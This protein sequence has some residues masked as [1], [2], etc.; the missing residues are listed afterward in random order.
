MKVSKLAEDFVRM[1]TFIIQARLTRPTMVSVSCLTTV[2]KELEASAT[3]NKTIFIVEYV[4]K[5]LLTVITLSTR[6][7]HK[8]NDLQRL[9]LQNLCDT[10]K[11][12][13]CSH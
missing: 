2:V 13:V 9:P 11:R 4:L 10:L 5:Q 3:S 1:N 6:A 8:R 7:L 12:Q